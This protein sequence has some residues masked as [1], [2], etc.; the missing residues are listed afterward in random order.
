MFNEFPDVMTVKQVAKAIGFSK[1]I[2][3]DLLR[4]GTIR[5]FKIGRTYRVPKRAV[6]EYIESNLSGGCPFE[7]VSN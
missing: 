3:Y 2:V 4:D 5:H 6:F 1:P 7:A